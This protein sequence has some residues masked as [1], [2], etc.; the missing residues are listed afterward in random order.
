MNCVIPSGNIR[1]INKALHTLAKVGDELYI[2]AKQDY[3]QFATINQNKT[4]YVTF[5]FQ[6]VFFSSYEIGN[7]RSVDTSDALTCKL[8]IKAMLNIFKL[9]GPK[10][11]NIDW[12][13][14]EFEN[15]PTR[16][17]LKLKYKQ[18]IIVNHSIRLI[19]MEY[20]S[21]AYDKDK[22]PNK[23]NTAGSF[24]GQILTNFQ[25][26]D[27]DMSLEIKRNK[28]TIRNYDVASD[29]VGNRIRS[30]VVLNSKEFTLYQINQECNITMCFKP[31]RA[32]VAF[33]E[34]FTLP[35]L[36]NVDSG[37]KP[38]IMT[39]KNAIFEANFILSTLSPDGL[40]Q[41]YATS[42]MFS[43]A[44]KSKNT[45]LTKDDHTMIEN[46]NWDSDF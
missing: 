31:F 30:Q 43:T 4:S 22:M 24:Y 20:I 23:I 42:N 25:L 17:L 16:I 44:D 36:M 9:K 19:D 38:V 2:D 33:A 39:I 18:D 6:S 40:T 29:N 41:S 32:A 1:I 5:D 7:N 10:E 37:G 15:D 27:E 34:A 35:I 3:L 12:C 28:V 26:S 45:E 8:H 13:K 14:I 46:I 21:V 11:K